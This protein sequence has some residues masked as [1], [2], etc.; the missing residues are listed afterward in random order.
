MNTPNLLSVVQLKKHF[1]LGKAGLFSLNRPVLH[2]VENVSFQVKE[3][4]TFAIVGESGCGKSTLGR[5]V[6][7]LLRPTSGD[8]FYYA[9]G[10]E[11][12]LSKLTEKELLPYRKQLQRCFKIP[13]LHS[14]RV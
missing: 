6:L 8:V 1:P 14:I 3:G 10:E 5:T 7:Q 13:I 11:I 2:A 9:N 4:E 12:N